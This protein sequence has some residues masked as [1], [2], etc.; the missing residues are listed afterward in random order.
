MGFTRTFNIAQNWTLKCFK[1]TMLEDKDSGGY[2][3][4]RLSCALNGRKDKDGNYPKGIPVTVVC[5]FDSCTIAEGDY[6][7]QLI[8]VT[9][10]VD[11][12]GF[13]DKNTGEDRSSLTIYADE[14]TIHE[15]PSHNNGSRK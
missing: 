4:V 10:G 1:Q 5:K 15:T 14:V 6:E 7:N 12:T 8:N 2:K 9:G 3:G 13:K 11:V